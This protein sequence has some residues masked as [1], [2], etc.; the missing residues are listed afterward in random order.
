MPQNAT[1]FLS[2]ALAVFLMGDAHAEDYSRTV[3][4]KEFTAFVGVAL[5]PQ[6]IP[7]WS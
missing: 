2:L 5:D 6:R 1:Y 3:L 4:V 7:G